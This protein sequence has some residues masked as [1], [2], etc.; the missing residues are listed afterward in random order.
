MI[1][2]WFH[3]T[4]LSIWDWPMFITNKRVITGCAMSRPRRVFEQLPP[5][6]HCNSLFYHLRYLGPL[7]FKGTSMDIS[8]P[9]PLRLRSPP[10]NLT[11]PLTPIYIDW[12]PVSGLVYYPTHNSPFRR[13]IGKWTLFNKATKKT[14][15]TCL[16]CQR[17]TAIYAQALI[18]RS[19]LSGF[20][21]RHQRDQLK[22]PRLVNDQWTMKSRK[23]NIW[24]GKVTWHAQKWVHMIWYE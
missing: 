23:S 10:V 7:I 11:T 4:S 5:T 9:L 14:G 15:E 20:P 12:I 2:R 17:C 24:N 13:G 6:L 8:W 1:Q 3:C 19:P 18:Y 21:P 22:N 16:L